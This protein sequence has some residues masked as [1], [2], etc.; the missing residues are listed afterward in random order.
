MNKSVSGFHDE[1]RPPGTPQRRHD[2]EALPREDRQVSPGKLA[3]L[4]QPSSVRFNESSGACDP[5][6]LHTPHI[7][8][9]PPFAA[10]DGAAGA[11]PVPSGVHDEVL[12]RHQG[13]GGDAQDHRPLRTDGEAAGE[14]GCSGPCAQVGFSHEG[15]IPV[16]M[17]VDLLLSVETASQLCIELQKV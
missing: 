16:L 11:G 2:P 1:S 15:K 5:P 3:P 14:P 6:A 8:A 10:P 9:P 12:P 4:T 7:E 13:E 17:S